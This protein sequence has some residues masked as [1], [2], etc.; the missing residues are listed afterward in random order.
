MRSLTTNNFDQAN[1][2]YIQFWVM[3]P[4]ENYSITNEEGLPQGVDPSDPSNQIGDMYINLGNVSEDIL[5]D[6]RKMYENG[7]PETGGNLNTDLTTWGKVPKN[8]SIIYSFNEQ[9]A[10][11]ANQDVG[12]DGLSDAE[13]FSKYSATITNFSKLNPNDPASDN[14]QFFRGSELDAVN[15]SIITRYK[16]YNNT[17]GNSPTLNQSKEAY[18]TSSTTYPDVEDIN[19]DQTMNTV[20]SYY[21]YKVSMNRNDLVVGKNFIVDEKTTDVTLENG[22]TQKT[23][24]YQFRVPIRS[25]IPKNGISDFNS[26]RFIRLFLTNFK[27]PV[28]VR[29][30]ELDLVRGDWRR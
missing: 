12:F 21:E 11:R 29:F 4:Y 15:A 13:E 2:E 25:G 19:R 24:W 18:P 3:D 17:E 14:F 22:A 28:V 23:R 1:V 26:I 6:S 20:E 5:K 27:M 30:G 9:D 8:P 10:A 16:N 7:L